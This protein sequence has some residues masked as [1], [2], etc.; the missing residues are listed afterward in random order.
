[1]KLKDIASS[2]KPL[3]QF[4]FQ[5]FCGF[6][7]QFRMETKNG[8]YISLYTQLN[9]YYISCVILTELRT[10]FVLDHHF[11]RCTLAP[12]EKDKVRW[13]EWKYDATLGHAPTW[14]GKLLQA[15]KKRRGAWKLGW[16]EEH[17]NTNVPSLKTK[18]LELP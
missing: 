8:V 2:L 11:P 14:H 10:C 1:M 16:I 18:K 12:F 13:P 6:T 17:Q 4:V 7:D 3:A 15:A 9:A 5:T